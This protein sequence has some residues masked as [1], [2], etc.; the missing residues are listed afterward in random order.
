VAA[1]T[2]TCTDGT[3][4]AAFNARTSGQN[5]THLDANCVFINGLDTDSLYATGDVSYLLATDT[6]GNAHLNIFSSSFTAS[7]VNSPT[8]TADSGY[9][10]GSTS[11]IDTNFNPSTNGTNFVQDNASVFIWTLTNLGS[12][13]D[14]GTAL[15][16]HLSSANLTIWLYP[17]FS[18][19]NFYSKITSTDSGSS[20][21]AVGHFYGSE[22]TNSLN[23]TEYA[24][25]SS[26]INGTASAAL[27]NLDIILLNADRG[28]VN[29]SPFTGN[30]SFVWIG[31]SLGATLQ[32]KLYAR[33]HTYMQ[34][35][36]G[37]P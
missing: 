5:N 12:G 17:H 35:I 1:S 14:Y 29:G 33:V 30:L 34:T 21:A 8:F 2:R 9:V 24:D 27:S 3:H 10:G 37:A 18:D 31:S 32:A 19:N 36:A 4:A 28:S 22:R 20:F 6:T 13:T 11:S 7:D 26:Q 25:T 23:T 16:Q 15:G